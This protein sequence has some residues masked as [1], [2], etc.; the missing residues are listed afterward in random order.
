MKRL[1]AVLT[2]VA[3]PLVITGCDITENQP[4]ESSSAVGIQAQQEVA[5]HHW[6]AEV[7]AELLLSFDEAGGQLPEGIAIDKTGNIFVSIAP[8]GQVWKIRNGSDTPEV[9]GTIAG[10]DAS[11]G[12]VGVLGL[13]TDAPGNVYAGVQSSNADANGVWVLDRRSGEATRIEGSENIAFANDV[14]FDKEGNL[15][16]TDSVLGAIWRLPKHGELEPWLTGDENLAGTGVLGLGAP[17][18]ANG[19]E[20]RQ[21]TLFVANTEKGLVVAVPVGPDGSPGVSS[22]VAAFPEIEVQP[23]VFLP[24]AADGLALDVF[25]NIYVAQINLSTIVKV[26][27]NGDVSVVFSGDPLDWPSSIKFGTSRAHQKTL[28]AVNFSIGEGFGD[29]EP[30]VGPGLV[31]LDLGVPG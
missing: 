19:I 11:A 29:A 5:A 31:A 13:A 14:A 16:I 21:G 22:I 18:G 15:Y 6:N 30:R 25:G 20:Y 26:A 1:S 10:I 7:S 23:G 27:T 8:L 17:V 3:V 9:F 4:L 28:F 12:D 2:F 24:S